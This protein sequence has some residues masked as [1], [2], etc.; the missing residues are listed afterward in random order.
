MILAFFGMPRAHK[1][2]NGT[3]LFERTMVSPVGRRP[4]AMEAQVRSQA[5]AC[6]ICG[7][8]RIR[9]GFSPSTAVSSVIIITSMFCTNLPTLC[10][11]NRTEPRHVVADIVWN[12]FV[13]RQNWLNLLRTR[14]QIADNLRKNSVACANLSFLGPYFW[15]FQWRLSP[16]Y[17][18]APPGSGPASQRL[19]TADSVDK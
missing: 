1:R 5:R 15:L 11:C 14:T 2:T 17:R 10:N 4:V 19:V 6:G 3:S 13:L 12:S 8:N 7:W 9:T 16:S 18:L